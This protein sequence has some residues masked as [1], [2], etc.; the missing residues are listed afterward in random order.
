MRKLNDFEK[1]ISKALVN[2][3]HGADQGMVQMATVVDDYFMGPKHGISLLVLLEKKQVAMSIPEKEVEKLRE[4]FLLVITVFNLLQYLTNEGLILIVGEEKVRVKLGE[5]YKNG[6]TSFI[7]EP[8]ASFITENLTKYILV[9]EEFKN[10]VGSNFKNPEQVR[11]QQTIIISAIAL[12]ISISLGVYGVFNSYRNGKVSDERYEQIIS[13]INN[14]TNKIETALVALKIKPTDY[15]TPLK[16]IN[17][18]L[19]SISKEVTLLSK[20]I[21]VAKSIETINEK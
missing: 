13:N 8:I 17:Q 15:S 5:Q 21:T 20:N 10:I 18:N 16:A 1:E 14:I 6:Q 2:H 4:K 3:H 9:S 12:I 11:H 7:P 19:Q